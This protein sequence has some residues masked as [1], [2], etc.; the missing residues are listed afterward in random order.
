M[1]KIALIGTALALGLTSTAWAGAKDKTS[2]TLIDRNLPGGSVI[3]N[4]TAK[5][6]VKAKGCTTQLQAQTVNLADG[7]IV[8]CILEADVITGGTLLGGNS[9]IVTGEAKKGKLK[10]KA[11]LGEVGILG[12]GCGD[13]EAL[14][15]NGQVKCYRDDPIFRSDAVAPGSWRQN[16]ADAGMP[17]TSPAPGTTQLKGNPGVPVVVGLCQ[18][19][20]EGE[21]IIPP[22]TTEWALT[23]QRTAVE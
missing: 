11:D 15:Y 19:N 22:A 17:L 14:S 3:N 21:R 12:S 20:A 2:N 4:T 5:T 7:E 16:C 6:K 8:I 10:L 13:T 9:L 23:G 18:G 1:R